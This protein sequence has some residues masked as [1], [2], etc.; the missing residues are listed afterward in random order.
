MEKICLF[1]KSY[2]KD[3]FR[4]RRMADSVHRFNLDNIP[5]YLSVPE[6]DLLQFQECFG[7][8]PCQF[9]TDEEVLAL[10]Q[11]KNGSLPALYPQH[12][13]QQIVKLEFWRLGLCSNYAW[14]D[15][16]S[17]FIKPFAVKDFFY[18]AETPYLIEEKFTVERFCE[19]W[20]NVPIKVRDKRIRQNQELIQKFRALFGN[21]S[22]PFVYFGEATPVIWSCRVLQSFN[23]DYL[24]A[25]GINLYQLLY[26]YPCET[27][28][29]GEFLH[30]SKVIPVRP[31]TAMFKNFHYAD[32][33]VAAEALGESEYSISK[34]YFG[35]T[36]QSN[37][38]LF[39]KNKKI[40][41]RL[42]K[43][44]QEILRAIGLLRFK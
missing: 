11:E 12:L 6:K 3:M 9:I 44:S 1:C 28:L 5:L 39:K 16:D 10:S 33:F 32:E 41:P 8:I 43:H 19:K 23:A 20:Q 36:M 26:Q 7:D 24:K 30:F 4:A 31:R 15:S 22:T 17:Y 21:N 38:L 40:I 35:I 25:K 14:I 34:D 18:D 2:D 29:Y 37:W 13:V 27:H 42:K